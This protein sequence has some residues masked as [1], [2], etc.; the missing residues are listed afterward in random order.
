MLCV[1]PGFRFA[2]HQF[3]GSVD[4]FTGLIVA[5]QVLNAEAKLS[6]GDWL[7]IRTPSQRVR[8]R[9]VG[10]P[11]IRLQRR[12]WSSIAIAGLPHGMDV[13]GLIAEA[14]DDGEHQV[15]RDRASDPG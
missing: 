8:V 6:V 11:L 5:G 4:G 14:V 15:E 10:F 7:E 13:T 3:I 12:D 2:I 9:C 1:V